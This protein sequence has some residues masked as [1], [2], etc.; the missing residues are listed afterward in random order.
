MMEMYKKYHPNRLSTDENCDGNVY[1]H[2]SAK[3]HPSAKLGPHVSIGSNVVIEEGARVKNSIIL[4]GTMI[5]KHACILNRYFK[6][7]HL[8]AEHCLFAL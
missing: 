4:D 7:T 8:S 6:G 3:V 1:I 5:K 2:P